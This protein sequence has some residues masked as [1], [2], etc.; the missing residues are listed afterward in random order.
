[1]AGIILNSIWKDEVRAINAEELS[2]WILQQINLG[3]LKFKDLDKNFRIGF[4]GKVKKLIGKRKFEINI[5]NSYKLNIDDRIVKIKDNTK[6][7]I[8]ISAVARQN[9]L[10]GLFVKEIL[11]EMENSNID[12]NT[13]E[14]VLEIGLD[15]LEK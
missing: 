1:M 5:Y 12:K 7:D 9:N 6:P 15:I 13:L 10:K 3:K 11:N 8:D 4:S 2:M 14:N